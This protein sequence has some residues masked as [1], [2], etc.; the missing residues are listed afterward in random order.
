[1]TMPC[2]VI[3]NENPNDLLVV[4]TCF[5][6]ILPIESSRD[7]DNV[8]SF[9]LEPININSVLVEFRVSLLPR[10]HLWML[11]KSRFRLDCVECKSALAYVMWV[12][13]ASILGW[14]NDKQ[15]G[16]SLI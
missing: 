15:F 2:H 1:M 12:S 11:L 8:L 10:S 13:S 7:S 5:M 14:Q 3:I 16:K 9:C 6:G 4:E